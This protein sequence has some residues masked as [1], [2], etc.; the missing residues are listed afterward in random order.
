MLSSGDAVGA[1]R[2]FLKALEQNP[3]DFDANLQL[4]GIRHRDQRFDEALTYLN[5]ALA[6]RP[7]DLAVR[8]ATASV[9][10]AQGLPEKAL[11][12]L[13]AVVKE[14]P[15]YIDARRAAGDD[16]LPAQAS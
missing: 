16:L 2:Q 5:R 14:A 6:V 11:P 9:Y 10:L 8:H 4:G 3:N 1:N 15:E 7:T 12:L 13:E